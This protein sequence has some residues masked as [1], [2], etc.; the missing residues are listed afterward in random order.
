MFASV[1]AKGDA[2]EP[3]AG[4]A[5]Q[6]PEDGGLFVHD[7]VISDDGVL[8]WN[9]GHCSVFRSAGSTAHGWRHDERQIS[10][11]GRGG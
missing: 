5:A 6:W 8:Q 3:S 10:T 2:P 7:D 4:V 9:L 11:T 1:S